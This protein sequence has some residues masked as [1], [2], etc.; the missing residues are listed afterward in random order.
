K[1][2]VK[3]TKETQAVER[4]FRQ[5]FA[6][7]YCYRHDSV[8]LRLL[9]IDPTFADLDQVQRF[10]CIEPFLKELPQ[11]IQDDLYFILLLAPGE[12]NTLRYGLRYQEFIDE[13]PSD[14]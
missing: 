3:T 5:H 10:K 12:E 1:K 9:V 14:L 6:E 8:T 4:T 7:A 13:T 2:K 11:N